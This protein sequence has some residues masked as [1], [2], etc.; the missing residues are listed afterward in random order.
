MEDEFTQQEAVSLE[1]LTQER[2]YYRTLA[3]NRDR[4]VAVLKSLLQSG[5]G[6]SEILEVE[7][8][9]DA[10]MAVC[11]E[12]CGMTR[13]AVLLKD[14]LDPEAITYRVRAFHGLPDRFVD[15]SGQEEELLLFRLPQD[16]GLLWQQIF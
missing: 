4:E 5:K 9:L 13:S 12:R 1:D 3:V 10:F 2:D 7:P 6:F 11:R 14:D 8:L 15:H 16:N